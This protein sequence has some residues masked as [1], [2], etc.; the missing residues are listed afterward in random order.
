MRKTK[1]ALIACGLS[2]LFC[3]SAYA[4]WV[5]EETK[6]EWGNENYRYE[7][8]GQYLTNQWIEFEGDWYYLGAD[9]FMLFNITQNIDGVNYTFD[10]LGRWT[11]QSV[12]QYHND[13]VLYSNLNLNYSIEFDRSKV[14]VPDGFFLIDINNIETLTFYGGEGYI[15]DVWNYPRSEFPEY[16]STDIN[17]TM[18]YYFSPKENVYVEK[19]DDL[20][21]T[22][23]FKFEKTYIANRAQMEHIDVY[24]CTE[25][26]GSFMIV[27]TS[28]MQ[29]VDEEKSLEIINKIKRS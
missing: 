6:K 18:F 17:A 21:Q 10:S 20:I 16:P 15:V 25:E 12:L 27:I 24:T 23:D 9:G 19:T 13:Q 26:N 2:I 7:Q 11:E 5:P 3:F 28:F 4:G 14:I 8:D 1:I 29:R 22:N